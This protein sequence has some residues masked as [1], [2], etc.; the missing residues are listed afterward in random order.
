MKDPRSTGSHGP[1]YSNADWHSVR[2]ACEP[3]RD[4][5]ERKSENPAIG[6]YFENHV[7]AAVVECCFC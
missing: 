1:V 2:A 4:G 5:Y 6:R 7:E 3:L